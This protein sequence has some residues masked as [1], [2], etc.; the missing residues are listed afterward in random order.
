MYDEL[1][2]FLVQPKEPHNKLE[3]RYRLTWVEDSLEMGKGNQREEVLHSGTSHIGSSFT[4]KKF[5]Y[6]LQ[7]YTSTNYL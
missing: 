4:T 6:L 7:I 2:P 1:D 5:F 3:G